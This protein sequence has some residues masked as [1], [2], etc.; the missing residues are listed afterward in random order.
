[1]TN[2]PP[3]PN[4]QLLTEGCKRF[5]V[6]ILSGN[7]PARSERGRLRPG[8]RTFKAR[9]FVIGHCSF[10]GHCSLVIG[11]SK[12]SLAIGHS[13]R[14]SVIINSHRRAFTLVELILVMALL[15]IVLAVS[16]PSLSNFFHGRTLDSEARRLMALTR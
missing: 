5:G 14:S 11:H 3:V 6:T 9:R 4:T 13:K 2:D 7:A 10:I 8:V 1:M 16:A 12:R 15:G